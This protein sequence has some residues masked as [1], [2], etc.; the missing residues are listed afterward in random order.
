MLL[1]DCKVTRQGCHSKCSRN[2]VFLRS[3]LYPTCPDTSNGKCWNPSSCPLRIYP[4]AITVF[5]ICSPLDE[6]QWK[7]VL[8]W[9]LC[10][11]C[12]TFKCWPKLAAK[13]RQKEASSNVKARKKSCAWVPVIVLTC[14]GYC[15]FLYWSFCPEHMLSPF[16][17]YFLAGSW[18]MP[19]AN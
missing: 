7:A 18:V 6:S 16:F 5:I 8:F 1:N 14:Q 3:I 15:T 10:S 9:Q 4:N 19:C 17:A 2:H 13:S 11:H 12:Y